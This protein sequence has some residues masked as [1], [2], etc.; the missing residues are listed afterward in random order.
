[1]MKSCLIS[2]LVSLVSLTASWGQAKGTQ[3]TETDSTVTLRNSKVRV[4]FPKGEAFDISKL[5]L[6]GKEL[7]LGKGYNTVPWTLTYKGPQGENPVLFPSHG[8]YAGWSKGTK[9]GNTAI[10]F[11]W[12]MRLTYNDLVPVV[13]TVSVP[14]DS[15]LVYWDIQAGT[16]EGWLISNTQFPRVTVTRPDDAK[17]ITSA[18]WGAEY[19]LKNPQVYASSYPSVT[20]S[21]QLLL[22]HNSDGSVYY[23]TEDKEACGKDFRA[24]VGEKSVTLL[25]DIV[26]SEGWSDN[27]TETFT[28]PWST[29]IGYSNIGWQDAATKWYRPFTFTTEWGSKPLASRNIPQWLLDT[30]IWIRAKGVNDTV[31]SAVNKA[32]DLYGKN[33]F[34]HWYF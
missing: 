6:S 5:T 12:N 20:G 17:L 3:I 24:A 32:I 23:A 14:D 21:M 31:R 30:D 27:V 13:M 15:E 19:E 4:E 28:V 1:M 11:K 25:T 9:N 33:T 16:P 18:G 34:V 2:I 8:E 22:L 10:A 7:I 29:V 26:A